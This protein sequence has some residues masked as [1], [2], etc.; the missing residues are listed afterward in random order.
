LIEEIEETR[1][2]RHGPPQ[3]WDETKRQFAQLVDK[4]HVGSCDWW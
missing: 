1:E 2:D 4:T 3:A